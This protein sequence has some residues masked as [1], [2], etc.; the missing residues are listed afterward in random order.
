MACVYN[1]NDPIGSP[2]KYFYPNMEPF[3]KQGYLVNISG[4]K[5][6]YCYETEACDDHDHAF[7]NACCMGSDSLEQA[8]S[9]G[10]DISINWLRCAICNIHLLQETKQTRRHALPAEPMECDVGKN[11]SVRSLRI[12]RFLLFIGRSNGD[13]KCYNAKVETK[14]LTPTDRASQSAMDAFLTP[15]H[16]IFGFI[17]DT[18]T[19]KVGYAIASRRYHDL[20][21]LLNVSVLGGLF[22]AAA[23]FL[24]MLGIALNDSLAGWVLN[25][26]EKSNQALI[27]DGCT[28]IPSTKALLRNARIYWI[29]S[30]V[31][32]IPSFMSKGLAGFFVGILELFPYLFP[33]II[34]AVVPISLWFG[35]LSNTDI[36]PLTILAISQ[37][38]SIWIIA[39]M[40]FLYLGLRKDIREKYKLRCLCRC[41]SSESQANDAPSITDGASSKH[42]SIWKLVI[43]CVAEGFQL[44]L[45]DVAIQLSKYDYN[46]LSGIQTF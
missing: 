7:R 44:M 9:S 45:V 29:L 38:A 26:S 42:S 17:E 43:E 2:Y 6:Q 19:V 34:Q 23:A 46:I 24:A 20:N 21:V 5:D 14:I 3:V 41:D 27:D 33:G 10:L 28:F 36:Y 11:V 40:Y 13:G 25:P 22:C 18:M 16:E 37:C 12:L 32:W 15:I 30:T 39:M 31:T 35:L 4:Y 1:P 8:A